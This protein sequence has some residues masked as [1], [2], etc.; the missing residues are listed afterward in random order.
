[1]I[2]R[3]RSAFIAVV[4]TT[5]ACGRVREHDTTRSLN[6]C[7]IPRIEAD[8]WQPTHLSISAATLSL[9]HE[10]NEHHYKYESSFHYSPDSLARPF[11]APAPEQS[12]YTPDREFFLSAKYQR[13]EPGVRSFGDATDSS[14]CRVILGGR[15]AEVIA[16]RAVGRGQDLWG[17]Y[18]TFVAVA[19]IALDTNSTLV[20]ES[21]GSSPRSQ[22][23]A[24]A[25]F[26]S[27]VIDSAP[28][29]APP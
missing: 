5:L 9:P 26:R 18:D 10:L 13:P 15:P 4:A 19:D 20:L 11:P 2:K 6:A 12:W 17:K 29:F 16:F 7:T 27:L 8:G 14:Y 23:Q 24:L 1:V 25:I 28:G 21:S 3:K 22:E